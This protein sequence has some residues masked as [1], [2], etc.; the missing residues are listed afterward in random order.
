MWDTPPPSIRGSETSL[1]AGV[2]TSITV[3]IVGESEVQLGTI[4]RH[5]KVCLRKAMLQLPI[6]TFSPLLAAAATQWI[7]RVTNYSMAATVAHMLLLI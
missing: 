1:S 3:G 7:S 4:A 2:N 6:L 5:I